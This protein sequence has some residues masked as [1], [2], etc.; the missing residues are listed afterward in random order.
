MVCLRWARLSPADLF[1]P[2]MDGTLVRW[3]N[4]SWPGRCASLSSVLLLAGGTLVLGEHVFEH[5]THAP[6]VIVH[7]LCRPV[8]VA[9]P[10]GCHDDQVVLMGL[11]S[12]A[13]RAARPAPALE[14]KVG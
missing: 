2:F 3:H 11:L 5:I 7:R 12:C 6:E 14:Q 9:R 8:G 4:S 1:P 13:R 10:Q